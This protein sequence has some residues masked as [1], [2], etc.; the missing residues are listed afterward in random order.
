MNVIIQSIIILC[1]IL[2]LLETAADGAPSAT[3]RGSCAS[4]PFTRECNSISALVQHPGTDVEVQNWPSAS[5][6]RFTRRVYTGYVPISG[7]LYRGY[8]AKVDD[9][10]HISFEMLPNGCAERHNTS[11]TAKELGCTYATNAG[12]FNVTGTNCI[13][14]IVLNGTVLQSPEDFGGVNFGLTSDRKIVSGYISHQALPSFNFET[15]VSGV[16]FLVREGESFIDQS[17]DLNTSSNF[18]LEKAPR[19]S[20]GTFKNGSVFVFQTDGIETVGEGLSLYEFTS[21]LID[22][23]GA[24]NVVNLDGGGSSVSV[25]DGHVISRPTCLDLP[26]P[27]CQRAVTTIAC[28]R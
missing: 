4:Q 27:V 11:T 9:L 6:E 5:E 14:N 24:W 8:Y 15:L 16:G 12:F 17:R 22:V 2:L 20:I 21:V 13:G 3:S 26:F 7:R 28:F 18:V 10:K 1:T 23:V 25:Y 19:T